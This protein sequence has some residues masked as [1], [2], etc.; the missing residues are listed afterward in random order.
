MW[1]AVVVLIIIALVLVYTVRHFARAFRSQGPCSGCGC[2]RPPEPGKDCVP[3]ECPGH[4]IL[5]PIEDEL[6]QGK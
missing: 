5:H 4:D 2:C 3:G 6:R 1:Q